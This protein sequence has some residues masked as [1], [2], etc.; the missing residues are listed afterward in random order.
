MT[1]Q[2]PLQ[3]D[4][5]QVIRPNQAPEADETPPAPDQQPQLHTLQPGDVSASS[6]QPTASD[7]AVKPINPLILAAGLILLLIFVGVFVPR[8]FGGISLEKY[9]NSD[10]S[11]D[12]PAQYLVSETDDYSLFTEEEGEA[13][14]RSSVI[15]TFEALP[16]DSGDQYKASLLASLEP[17]LRQQSQLNFVNITSLEDFKSDKTT[18]GSFEAL[19]ATGTSIGSDGQ[20]N[21]KLATLVVI[22]DKGIYSL[23]VY[24]HDSDPDLA[25][26]T[27]KI[28]NSLKLL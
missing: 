16:A 19:K 5:N 17:T 25:K 7:D 6:P 23:Y 27:N 22:G 26:N 24:A 10:Y 8:F 1:T 14:T 21:G 11:L 15:S 18:H 28:L 12:V 9:S 4:P 20:A 3:P 2:N 13:D